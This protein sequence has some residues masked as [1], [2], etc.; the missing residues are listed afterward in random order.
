MY[1]YICV[2]IF[3]VEEDKKNQCVSDKLFHIQ[4]QIEDHSPS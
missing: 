1:M 2:I 3:C 4:I